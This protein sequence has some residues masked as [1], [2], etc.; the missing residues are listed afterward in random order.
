MTEEAIH[1]HKTRHLNSSIE[2]SP[3]FFLYLLF[4]LLKNTTCLL[5]IVFVVNDL[6]KLICNEFV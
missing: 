3:I 5:I 2:S 6:V 1:P 4:L